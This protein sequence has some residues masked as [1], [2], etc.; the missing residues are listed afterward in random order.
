MIEQWLNTKLEQ[1][2]FWHA[3][4]LAE[5]KHKSDG[6]RY[7]VLKTSTG[8]RVVNKYN[9]GE[10]NR[11]LPKAERIDFRRMVQNHSYVTK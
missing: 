10:T 4:R 2:K 1:L 11:K 7:W 6:C 8:Y 5:A 3:K 9:I